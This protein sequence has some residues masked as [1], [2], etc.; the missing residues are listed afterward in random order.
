MKILRGL[1]SNT[2]NY[3]ESHKDKLNIGRNIP[4]EKTKE[5]WNSIKFFSECVRVNRPCIIKEGAK[6]WPAF[7]KWNTENSTDN[8][9]K[10]KKIG[11]DYLLDLIGP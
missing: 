3:L 11:A 4:G 7:N 6:A 9:E 10:T 2:F 1:N 8:E 5:D